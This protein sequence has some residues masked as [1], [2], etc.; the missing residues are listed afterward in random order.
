MADC[1]SGEVWRLGSFD[2][3]RIVG[4]FFRGRWYGLE[5]IVGIKLVGN[6]D[7]ARIK[8]E[9]LILNDY[10]VLCF[11][12]AKLFLCILININIHNQYVSAGQLRHYFAG[13]NV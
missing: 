5:I 13:D 7:T 4:E 2:S 11:S 12:I 10:A 6:N 8:T 9:L 3:T 1:S